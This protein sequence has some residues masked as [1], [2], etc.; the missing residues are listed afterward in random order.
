M[1]K[2]LKFLFNGIF[3]MLGLICGSLLS[4]WLGSAHPV[5]FKILGISLTIIIVGYFLYLILANLWQLTKRK[6]NSVP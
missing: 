2:F 4:F 5:L 6:D 3:I 1:N